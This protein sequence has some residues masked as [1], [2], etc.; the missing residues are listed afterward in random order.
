MRD[1]RYADRA[2]TDLIKAKIGREAARAV[3]CDRRS[4][5]RIPGESET[6]AVVSLPVLRQLANRLLAITK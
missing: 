3:V 5:A 4:S 6:N 2:L 1:A